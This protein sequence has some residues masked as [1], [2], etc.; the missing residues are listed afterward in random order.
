MRWRSE[1]SQFHRSDC[2][3]WRCARIAVLSLS[4]LGLLISFANAQTSKTEFVEKSFTEELRQHFEDAV[5]QQRATDQ[6]LTQRSKTFGVLSPDTPEALRN[7]YESA[8]SAFREAVGKVK[9]VYLQHHVSWSSQK[10]L[11][12][13]KEYSQLLNEAQIRL[14]A[15][16]LTIAEVFDASPVGSEQLTDLIFEMIERDANRD[17]Y[18]GLLP[19]A[20]SVIS[21]KIAVPNSILEAIGYIGYA[22]NDYEL[23]E[24][25][26]TRLAT[27]GTLPKLIAFTLPILT[28]QRQKWQRELSQRQAD[29]MRDDNPQVVIFTN[30]G[31]ITVELFEEEAPQAVA[32]FIFLAEQQGFYKKKMFFRVVERF[33]V[34]TGCERGDG[35]GHAGY[36]IQGEMATANHRNIFRGT[37]VLQAGFDEQM[38]RPV[39][40]SGSSQFYFAMLPQ[41]NLD[42]T[43]TAFGRIIDGLPVLG[44]LQRVDFTIEK[45]RKDKSKRADLIL[46]VK[47]LR[48]RNHEYVPKVASGHLP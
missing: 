13:L 39:P 42:G 8:F 45:E 46:D 6:L 19:I 28:E 17:M 2:C 36:T 23:A 11:Q 26:W 16:R 40:D 34:Q 31:Q 5:S 10:D 25:A 4:I 7:K 33:V 3:D 35:T 29:A 1:V 24:E 12:R 37:M 18:E 41:P 14:D 43:M 20:R 32:N 9:H 48:K 27:V 22:N 38:K 44:A 47:V 15:W 30:K 21:R